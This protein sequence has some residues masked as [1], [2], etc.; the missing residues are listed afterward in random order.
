LIPF[1]AELRRLGLGFRLEI[2]SD[3]PMRRELERHLGG[4]S[5][6]RFLGWQNSEN[7]WSHLAEWDAAVFFSDWEGGP[8]VL[9]EAMAAGALPVYPSMGGSLGDDYVPLV[10]PRCYYPAGDARAAARAIDVIA[11]LPARE[12]SEL[13]DKARRLTS[14]HRGEKY[15]ATFAA[16]MR[17]IATAPRIS[18]ADS[19]VRRSS[20]TDYL[21]LGVVTRLFPSALS[22]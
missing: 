15:Q 5:A 4:D 21:P 10:D 6:V 22:R 17:R 16:F 2:L 7:Y 3:G 14:R 20:L 13:R 19:N 18:R 11:K 8:I 9:L 1:V 12:R